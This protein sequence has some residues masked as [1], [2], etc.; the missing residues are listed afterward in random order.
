MTF[1]TGYYQFQ[2]DQNG[3][4]EL[5]PNNSFPED[6][7]IAIDDDR[8]YLISSSS[9]EIVTMLRRNEWDIEIAPDI[10]IVFNTKRTVLLGDHY[11][12]EIYRSIDFKRVDIRVN[13][14][15]YTIYPDDI[16][17]ESIYGKVEDMPI[18][19]LVAPYYYTEQIPD[20]SSNV[21]IIHKEDN[22]YS[23]RDVTSG[24]IFL[25]G[26]DITVNIDK[27][28]NVEIKYRDDWVQTVRKFSL[29]NLE[30]LYPFVVDY[31]YQPGG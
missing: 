31:G 11:A 28:D 9:N 17:C 24:I 7:R 26:S 27:D 6:V 18:D 4:Y 1:I 14:N 12:K 23:F 29:E 3:F 22:V 30:K 21:M 19:A 10:V 2:Y 13:K 16:I 8:I 5:F 15:E 25:E 20:N